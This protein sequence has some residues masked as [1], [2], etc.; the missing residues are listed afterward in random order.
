MP[1]KI[2]DN[3]ILM[4][5]NDQSAL[6]MIRSLAK[7]SSNVILTHH[8]KQR[9]EKRFIS[10]RQVFDCLHKGTISESPHKTVNGDWKMTLT[11]KSSGDI[12][13]VATVLTNDGNGNMIIV[14]T[15]F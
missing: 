3:V 4:K 10:I 13:N 5:L 1:K 14:V 8:A 12:V 7:D 15:T 6:K 2:P 11:A 9:M